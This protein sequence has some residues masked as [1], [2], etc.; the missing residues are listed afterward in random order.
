MFK[1][2]AWGRTLVAVFG[3]GYMGCTPIDTQNGVDPLPGI[4]AQVVTQDGVQIWHTKRDN[5][6][7]WSRIMLRD[8]QEAIRGPLPGAGT[9]P[10][11]GACADAWE[12]DLFNLAAGTNIGERLPTWPLGVGFYEGPSGTCTTCEGPELPWEAHGLRLAPRFTG[13][14]SEGITVVQALRD[15]FDTA[16]AVDGTPGRFQ[17]SPDVSVVPIR[18]IVTNPEVDLPPG[19]Y[20]QQLAEVLFD[21]LWRADVNINTETFPPL[22]PADVVSNWTHRIGCNESSC[23]SPTA[24]QPDVIWEQCNIQFRLTEY[25]TC[26]VLQNAWINQLTGDGACNPNAAS[27]QATVIKN[28]LRECLGDVEFDKNITTVVI[29][30]RLQNPNN[31]CIKPALGYATGSSNFVYV[32]RRAMINTSTEFV[33]AHELGHR[34]GLN[35]PDDNAEFCPVP[36]TLMCSRATEMTDYIRPFDC[37]TAWTKARQLQGFGP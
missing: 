22:S 13:A 33:L 18:L 32:E 5:P 6:P 31:P 12:Y 17:L 15:D 24:R 35:H 20:S 29:T 26:T 30:E 10:A 37:A 4:N 2:G 14:P 23:T 27:S 8:R 3:V 7:I 9:C 34:L 25:R 11:F 21:D 16:E 36:E 1:D 19:W 28:A